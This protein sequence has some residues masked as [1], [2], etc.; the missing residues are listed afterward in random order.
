MDRKVLANLIYGP[1][2]ISLEYA[3]QYW[4]LIPE[5]VETV[6][7]ITGKR[8]KFFT[9]P[10]GNFSYR[11]LHKSKF[12]QGVLLVKSRFSGLP[13]EGGVE[14]GFFIASAEKAHPR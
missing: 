3:L 9:T 10:L 6:T 1:S 5:R 7:S 14:T 4:G 12:I 11:Y 13:G 8:N 2:Y